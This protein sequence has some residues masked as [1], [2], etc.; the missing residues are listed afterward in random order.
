MSSKDQNVQYLLCVIDL[1]T[2]YA[3]VKKVKTVFNTL[4]EIVNE[5]NW[6]LNKLWV[7]QARELYSKLMQEWLD[8]NI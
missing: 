2:K 6:K 3:W 8:N 4:I 1:F 7:D 5:S